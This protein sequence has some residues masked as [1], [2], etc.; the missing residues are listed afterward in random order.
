MIFGT[1]ALILLRETGL[2]PKL[3]EHDHFLAVMARKA[4]H[5]RFAAALKQHTKVTTRIRG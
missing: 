2:I 3:P 5:D 4:R 1:I